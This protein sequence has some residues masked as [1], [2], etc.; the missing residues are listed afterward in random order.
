MV[1]QKL[2]ER[3]ANSHKGTY[4]T[5]ALVCGSYSLAGAAV[6]SAK[7]AYRT[8]VGIVRCIVPKSIYPIVAAAVSEAVFSPFIK[9][10]TKALENSSA[11]LVG[12]GC[13][14]TKATKNTV[15]KILKNYKKPIVIDA[16]GINA[17][18][19]NIKIIKQFSENAVIT[20]HPK[21]ASRVLNVSV[22]EIQQNRE[23][24]AILLAQM[25]GAVCLLK[26]ANTL[27][28]TPR[29]EVYLLPVDNSGLATAGSGDVLSGIIVA[30]L[31]QGLTPIDAAV[32]GA[33]LHASAGEI[34]AKKLSQTSMC[35]TD[36]INSL[37]ELF[38]KFG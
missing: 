26:G 4:G 3:Q 24:Y 16:D 29:G 30:L 2:P 25:S 31:C 7:A 9:F 5:A 33:Y 21:E 20:P 34:A 38:L 22:N 35:A 27:I 12:C 36:I 1:L 32:C 6:L 19:S 23:K 18:S 11:C 15:T 10:S 17:I 37:P 8:G 14:N 28:S 13:S